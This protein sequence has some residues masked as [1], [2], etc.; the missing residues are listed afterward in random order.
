MF[1]YF[2]NILVEV[3]LIKNIYPCVQL[4]IGHLGVP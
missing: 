2:I 3:N 1:I 4:N